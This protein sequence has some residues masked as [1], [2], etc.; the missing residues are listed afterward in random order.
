MHMPR[1]VWVESSRDKAEL[2]ALVRGAGF[3]ID[4]KEPEIVMT[5]GGD[6][7]ILHAEE[8]YPGVPKLPIR[9][10]KLYAK[11]VSYAVDQIPKLLERLSEGK[12]KLVEEQKVEAVLKDQRLTGLNE[13]QI[14]TRLP[15]SAIRFS[16]ETEKMSIPEIIGDGIVAAA[17]HGSTAYYRSIGGKPFSKGIRIGFNNAWPRRKPIELKGTA[18]IK[19]LREHAWLAADNNPNMLQLSPGDIVE[20]SLSKETA[21]FVKI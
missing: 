12:Y 8:K 13:V 17:P 2:E 1:Q 16:F 5:Y 19:L 20:I 15:T 10:S 3:K 21:K 7:S 18:K 11:C 6:G 14:H 4:E 9:E